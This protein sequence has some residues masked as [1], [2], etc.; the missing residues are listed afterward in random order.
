[1]T[2]DPCARARDHLAEL[3]RGDALPDDLRAHVDA[4]A[5]CG[6]LARGS[7][8]MKGALDGWGVAPPA[9]DL[10]ERSLARL[11]LA[12]ASAEGEGQAGPRPRRRS[13]VELLTSVPFAGG[14]VVPFPPTRRQLALR[15]FTQAAA[16]LLLFAASTSFVAVF[17]PAVVH[18]ID[19]RHV[20]RCQE[21]LQTLARAA[22]AYAAEHPEA[23][24]LRGVALRQAL[25]DGGYADPHD[26]VCPGPRGK[27]L[28]ENSYVGAFGA[29][30]PVFWDRFGNHADGFNVVDLDGRVRCM[31]VD[32][33]Q[34]WLPRGEAAP[35]AGD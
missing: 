28:G 11:A 8:A 31:A 10:V 6:A 30:G 25:V 23:R 21:R 2:D 26:F 35:R 14:Q 20:H 32:D 7:A 13:S 27:D 4:C 17:Y 5:A 9:D 19:E 3:V 22:R 1:V 33:L 24:D 18:A 29:G 15:V 16:A 34:A 12:G